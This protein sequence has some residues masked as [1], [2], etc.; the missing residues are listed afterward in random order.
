MVG[1]CDTCFGEQ[2][3]ELFYVLFLCAKYFVEGGEGF[4][5]AFQFFAAVGS[6]WQD[7]CLVEDVVEGGSSDIE[8]L[9]DVD[10]AFPFLVC[11]DDAVAGGLVGGHVDLTFL[12]CSSLAIFPDVLA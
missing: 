6:G 12:F 1:D 4:C 8:L 2:V 9:F 5:V 10:D 7:S 3:F 11:G